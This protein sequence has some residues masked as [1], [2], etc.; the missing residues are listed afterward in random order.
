MSI[1]SGA[2]LRRPKRCV[3]VPFREAFS[4]VKKTFNTRDSKSYM[5]NSRRKALR[6]AAEVI[7]EARSIV[8]SIKDEEEEAFEGM[9]ENL[10]GSE[11][12]DAIQQYVDALEAISSNLED[13]IGQ[14]QDITAG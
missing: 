11:R 4:S 9:P 12:G 2:P 8:E 7:E 5:N 13:A 6:K 3:I 14:I 1:V 10:Q